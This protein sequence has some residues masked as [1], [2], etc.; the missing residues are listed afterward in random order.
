M[1]KPINFFK[2]GSKQSSSLETAT[3]RLPTTPTGTIR[4]S[5]FSKLSAKP[6]TDPTPSSIVDAAISVTTKVN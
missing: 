3:A 6:R 4:P 5:D 2:K 1:S